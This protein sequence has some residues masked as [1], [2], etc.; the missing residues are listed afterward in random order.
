VANAAVKAAATSS[1]IVQNSINVKAIKVSALS[2]RATTASAI[3]I[4][5]IF[6]V[7]LNIG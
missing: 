7:L 6:S 3:E 5:E 1:N 4:N 2:G